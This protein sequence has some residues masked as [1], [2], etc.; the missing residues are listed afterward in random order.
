MSIEYFQVEGCYSNIKFKCPTNKSAILIKTFED[1]DYDFTSIPQFVKHIKMVGHFSQIIGEN[2]LPLELQSIEFSDYF[3]KPIGENVLPSGLQSIV[4]G[5][6]FNQPIMINTLPSGLKSIEFDRREIIFGSYIDDRFSSITY[7]DFF[8]QPIEKDIL[9][10]GLQSIKFNHKFNHKFNQPIKENVLPCCLKSIVFGYYFNQPIAPGVL[11]TGLQSIVFGYQFNQPLVPGVLPTGLR[12][13]EFGHYFHQKL[14]IGLFPAG[15]ESIILDS[16]RNRINEDALPNGLKKIIFNWYLY[17]CE[18]IPTETKLYTRDFPK[19]I[20]RNFTYYNPEKYI[21]EKEIKNLDHLKEYLNIGEI[22][23]YGINNAEFF[24][25]D[26]EVK[27][28]IKQAKIES[29]L[30]ENTELEKK[31][32]EMIRRNMQLIEQL[33]SE[34]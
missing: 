13:I 12:S 19:K 22:Y 25:I 21:I 17:S 14:E 16:Y 34:L 20:T 30:N 23:T 33:E 8:N 6:Y 26:I 10:S 4:F 28:N 18:N 29:L 5:R 15:L 24:M 7:N 9:P 2:V 27:W 1:H 32:S 31:Y 3:N 11:P